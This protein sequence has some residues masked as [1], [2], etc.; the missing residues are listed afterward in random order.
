MKKTYT[1]TGMSCSACSASIERALNPLVGLNSFNVNLLANRL[2]VEFDESLLSDTQIIEVIKHVGYGAFEYAKTNQYKKVSDKMMLSLV[3]SII[4]MVVLF[5]ISMGHMYA[6]PLPAILTDHNN[7]FIFASVQLVLATIIYGLNFKYFTSGYKAL[8]SRHPNMDSLIAIGA[9]AAYLYGLY[10]IFK[11][12]QGEHQYAMD[13]YFET[14]AMILTLVSIGKTLESIS[15]RKTSDAIGK[16]VNLSPKHA[17]RLIDGQLEVVGL[18]SI[19]VD[20]I[21]VVKAGEIIPFDGYITKGK[22]T[23]DEA[24]ITGESLPA[25][26]EIDQK[27]IGATLNLTGYI[28]VRVSACAKDSTLSKIIELVESAASSKAPIA[29]FADRISA[30]FVPIVIGIALLTFIIWLIVT[31][32][33]EESMVF[34]I[35]VLVISCPCALGI[36]TPSAIMVATGVAASHGILIKDAKSLEIASKLKTIVFDKTGTITEGKPTIVDIISFDDDLKSIAYSLETLSD[37]PLASAI[38]STFK[39]EVLIFDTFSEISGKGILANLNNDIYMAGNQNLMLEHGI[40]LSAY[41]SQIDDFHDEGKTSLFFAKNKQLLGIICVADALK[42]S[43]VD[44]IKQLKQ[45]GIHTVML[46]GDNK[47]VARAIAARVGIDEYLAEVFPKDKQEAI[48]RFQINNQKV[49]MVGDGINDSPALMKADVGIAIGKG[50]DIAIE[51]ADIILVKN[52]L[53]DVVNFIKLS[54]ETLKNIKQNLF[55]ALIYNLIGIPLAAGLLFIPFGLKLNPMFGAFAMS[56]SSIS[57]VLNALRL[58]RFKSI[59]RREI[60]MNKLVKIEGMS[61]GHCQKRV[62]DTLNA[63]PGVSCKVDLANKQAT[64][65]GEIANDTLKSLVENAGYK[66]I[67]IHEG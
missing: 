44:A 57:V 56:V 54:S 24:M 42:Q 63:L 61:C 21:V 3:A 12:L 10:A 53:F 27:V 28:E 50:S 22:T 40:D 26:K 62:E 64:I 16:L 41:Q 38:T 67:D 14:G 9:L 15:K 49:A 33:V 11:I 31:Q 34:A 59:E 60:K 1:I 45:M 51:S 19:K 66:V 58:K 20:D 29:K 6:W 13:L 7:S 55:F 23:V 43:S 30:V 32:S 18:E 48:A 5:Y 8:V 65:T 52:N 35:A 17:T 39:E 25:L 2:D 47:R 37:H 4:L 36:A 46:T